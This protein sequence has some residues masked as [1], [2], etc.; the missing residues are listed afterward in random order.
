MPILSVLIGTMLFLVGIGGYGYSAANGHAS[1]TA[2]IPA[3]IGLLIFIFGVISIIKESLRKHLMHGALVV[4]VLGLLGT[5]QGFIKFFTLVSGGPVERPAAV[6]AQTI[7][8][9][10]CFIFVALG[11]KSFIDARKK[12]IA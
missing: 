1:P 5:V 11:V 4:A 3:V 12:R 2:L 7:T 6:I 10:L 8:A 9:V